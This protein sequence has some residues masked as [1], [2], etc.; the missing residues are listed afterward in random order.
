MQTLRKLSGTV[1]LLLC[2]TCLATS[3]AEAGWRRWGCSNQSGY[4]Y[5]S[6]TYYSN[7]VMVAPGVPVDSTAGIDGRQ[8]YQSAYQSPAVAPNGLV[9]VAPAYN[10]PGYYSQGNY[11][12][13]NPAPG[14]YDDVRGNRK[15]ED[16]RVQH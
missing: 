7:N 4:Y 10:G 12:S 13:R 11:Y 6:P 2:A 9:Y 5:V 15:V 1:A 3:Q 14:S 8:R 16:G